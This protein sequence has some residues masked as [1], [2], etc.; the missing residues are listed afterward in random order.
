MADPNVH[1]GYSGSHPGKICLISLNEAAEPQVVAALWPERARSL[2][3][4][5]A[6]MAGRVILDL[7]HPGSTQPAAPYD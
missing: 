1:V 6:A 2:G 7:E 3:F 5:L 4:A